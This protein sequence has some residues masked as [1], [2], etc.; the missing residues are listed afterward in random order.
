MG[1]VVAMDLAIG[2]PER[3]RALILLA[4]AA[5]LGAPFPSLALAAVD[6]AGIPDFS[7]PKKESDIAD[8]EMRRT[9]LTY[10]AQPVHSAISLLRAGERVRRQLGRIHCPVF[11]AHGLLDRVCPAKNAGR[12]AERLGSTDRTVVLLPRSRHIIT[13]DYDREALRARVRSFIERFVEP[14]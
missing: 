11:I 7:L 9:N 3:V 4:N 12:V 2:R 13:R 1:A 8:P 6:R 10:S 5:W 14:G